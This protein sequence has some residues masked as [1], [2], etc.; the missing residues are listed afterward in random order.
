MNK[1]LSILKEENF[2]IL[3]GELLTLGYEHFNEYKDS[4]IH[5]AEEPFER[6]KLLK[7]KKKVDEVVNNLPTILRYFLDGS[8]K[9]YK[10]ADVILDG[11]YLPLIAGQIGVA[12]LK[13][14]D[15]KQG[16]KPLK[17]YCN[18]ENIIAFPS[19]INKDDLKY[20]KDKIM[21]ELKI[22]FNLIQYDIK[23]DRDPV[24]LGIAQINKCM[25][26]LEV[27]KVVNMSEKKLLHNN[28][29]LILDGPVRFKKMQGR[30]FDIVQ[31]RNVIGVSKTFKPSFSIGKGKEKKDVGAITS[32]LEF[33]E[34][35]SVYKT[36]DD[37]RI[38]GQWYLR[39]RPRRAMASPLQGIIKMECFA[40][41]PEEIE[42]GFETDRIDTISSFLLQER[43]VTPF[44]SDHRWASHF[45]PIYL[46][47]KYIKS[48]F[49]GDTR[50]KA[51][52]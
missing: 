39:I 4:D 43:N 16:F 19:R 35:T 11:H 52:F 17:D 36:H 6:P 18:F 29:I 47:E 42:N 7:N 33:G 37:D 38:I 45:Y 5:P 12:V 41:S 14:L 40:T 49:L 3:P 9:T 26:D 15:N 32:R 2:D 1:I 30:Q 22:E 25:Q 24:D 31:F 50:F 10:I 21:K 27:E 46:A 34:R 51:L 8:R 13:R 28:A 44:K 20:L 48:S 23:K